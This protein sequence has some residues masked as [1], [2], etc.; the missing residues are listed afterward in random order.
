HA[1]HTGAGD[2]TDHNPTY[3]RTAVPQRLPWRTDVTRLVPP[4]GL[5][6]A[7][8][9]TAV[10]VGWLLSGP[11]VVETV[12]NYPGLGRLLIFAID[13]RDLPLLQAI[14]LIAALGFALSNLAA[15][16]LYAYLNPRIRLG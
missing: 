1:R 16:L 13:R 14:A 10:S 3:V 4:N 9:F 5:L 12:F 8:T 7:M 6:P 15:D 2:S 11:V